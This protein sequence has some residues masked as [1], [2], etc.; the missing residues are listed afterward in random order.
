MECKKTEEGKDRAPG[1]EL[2]SRADVGEGAGG[3]DRFQPFH[4]RSHLEAAITATAISSNKARID[5]NQA[6]ATSSTFNALVV[7]NVNDEVAGDDV[8]IEGRSEEEHTNDT[9]GKFVTY[10]LR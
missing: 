6:E 3:E 1:E 7:P 5:I 4:Q 2:F 10:R 8:G 9:D